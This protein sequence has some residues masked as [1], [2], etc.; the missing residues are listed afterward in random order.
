M[1]LVSPQHFAP[2]E[3][4][5]MAHGIRSII[6]LNS[7]TAK[8]LA[9]TVPSDNFTWLWKV[10]YSSR[11]GTADAHWF[12]LFFSRYSLKY[13]HLETA[14]EYGDT[15]KYGD[16]IATPG[17]E[18]K[19]RPGQWA[20]SLLECLSCERRSQWCDW[21]PRSRSKGKTPTDS[22][23]LNQTWLGIEQSLTMEAFIE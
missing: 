23:A 11:I 16:A 12:S 17:K 13:D 1:L 4:N 15:L 10:A 9:C 14:Q 18:H 5:T 3:R 19:D 22:L 7:L 2:A 20:G 21:P 6:C 8:S